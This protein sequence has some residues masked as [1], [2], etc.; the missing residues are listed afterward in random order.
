MGK[1]YRQRE[2]QPQP[3]N[4]CGYSTEFQEV[5]EHFQDDVEKFLRFIERMIKHVMK[6]CCVECEEALVR[7]YQV[8]PGCNN[9]ALG[10]E[11]SIHPGIFTEHPYL[12]LSNALT[13]IGIDYPE[14]I[15][16]VEHVRE[17]FGCALTVAQERDLE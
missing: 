7:G 12:S 5:A 1:K 4:H 8:S 2:V 9:I 10:H 6:A 13:I 15:K 11:V 3:I 16:E 17:C 14:L